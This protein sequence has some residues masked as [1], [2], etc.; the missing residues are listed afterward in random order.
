MIED[1]IATLV[2]RQLGVLLESDAIQEG[3]VQAVP[4]KAQAGVLWHVPSPDW[5]VLTAL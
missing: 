2:F 1:S 5:M 4:G 3:K